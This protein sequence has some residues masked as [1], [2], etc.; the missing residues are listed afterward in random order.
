M[1]I[2]HKGKFVLPIFLFVGKL[3]VYR[4]WLSVLNT[5]NVIGMLQTAK[6]FDERTEKIEYHVRLGA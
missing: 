4:F 3:S 6:M 2:E 1:Q 5:E